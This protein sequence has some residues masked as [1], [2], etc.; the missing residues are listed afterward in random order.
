MRTIISIVDRINYAIHTLCGILFGFV[1]LLTLYQVFARKALNSPLVWSEE[2]VRYSIIWIV[3]LGSAI[4]LRKGM[5]ISV[6]IVQ[7]LVPKF[8]RKVMGISVTVLNIV[9]LF[10]MAKYGFGIMETLAGQKTGALELP[11]VWTYAAIPIGACYS[12]LN[13]LVVLYE[14][15]FNIEEEKQDGATIL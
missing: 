14:Q 6:E 10:I 4:A 12:L 15:I 5:L 3:L 2:I 8:I 9:L 1:A 11:V 7:H 13:C